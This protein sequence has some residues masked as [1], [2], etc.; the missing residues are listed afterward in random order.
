MPYNNV[1]SKHNVNLTYFF[2]ALTYVYTCTHTCCRELITLLSP[3]VF[4][5][6]NSC[7]IY[8]YFPLITF[9][10]SLPVTNDF[11][12]KCL[13]GK[14]LETINFHMFSGFLTAISHWL[15]VC[16]SSKPTHCTDRSLMTDCTVID[17]RKN[18]LHTLCLTFF[19]ECSHNVEQS[20]GNIL[21]I[22]YFIKDILCF[23][24]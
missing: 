5:V 6:F 14:K 19:N 1:I 13:K 16:L 12:L 18:K 10:Q 20:K 4:L 23:W 3:N 8:K 2:D 22:N 11:F 21:C 15:D 17:P 9:L 24:K 7:F